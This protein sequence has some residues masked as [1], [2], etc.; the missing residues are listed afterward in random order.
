MQSILFSIC[1]NV[2]PIYLNIIIRHDK[3]E[4][5]IESPKERNSMNTHHYM[6]S[7]NGLLLVEPCL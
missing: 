3:V 7:N 4:W 5:S 1:L 2:S 6:D